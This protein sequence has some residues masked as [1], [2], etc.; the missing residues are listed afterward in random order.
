MIE[1]V[2][3]AAA[4]AGVLLLVRAHAGL[5]RGVWREA[6]WY[7]KA[8]LVVALLPIPGP[9][10]ELVGAARDPPR[11]RTPPINLLSSL[12]QVREKPRPKDGDTMD[13]AS[14]AQGAI[15]EYIEA[16]E[17]LSA[18]EYGIRS[19]ECC[20]GPF[21]CCGI[22]GAQLVRGMQAATR[23][24]GRFVTQDNM[25]L[26][27]LKAARAEQREVVKMAQEIKREIGTARQLRIAMAA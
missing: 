25:T 18:I 13:T 22:H 19:I 20:G 17:T 8:A 6:R 23:V 16:T 9:V 11:D 2:L 27:T 15:Q 5:I 14:K 26:R 12:V 1:T 21:Y 10:D 4:I 7:E 24:T 3:L